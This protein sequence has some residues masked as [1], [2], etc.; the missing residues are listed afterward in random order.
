MAMLG[1]TKMSS[2]GQVVIPEDIRR[3]L[4]LR[5]GTQFVVLGEGDV[6]IL[7]SIAP[8]SMEDFD[9]QIR[10]A[11]K[12]ARLAGLRPKDVSDAVATVRRRSRRAGRET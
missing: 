8:P 3:R 7:R 10:K 1:T 12:A 6:V 5:A 4:G 9:S 2:K 11:R